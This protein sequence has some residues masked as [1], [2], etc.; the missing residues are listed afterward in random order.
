MEIQTIDMKLDA[1]YSAVAFVRKLTKKE[2]AAY[3]Q[4]LTDRKAEYDFTGKSG[5]TY[6]YEHE[7]SFPTELYKLAR[8][9]KLFASMVSNA[10]KKTGGGKSDAQKADEAY[11]R[12]TPAGRTKFLAR[13]NLKSTLKK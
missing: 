6:I 8:R 1:A 11:E 13:H 2:V 4:S 5:W 9:Y 3:F 10:K 12:L 7:G